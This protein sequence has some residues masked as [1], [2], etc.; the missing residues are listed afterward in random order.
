[1]AAQHLQPNILQRIVD[2]A[3][4][5]ACLVRTAGRLP[6]ASSETKAVTGPDLPNNLLRDEARKHSRAKAKTLV[7]S[8]GEAKFSHIAQTALP[9][10]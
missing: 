10:I 6:L 3:M 8:P 4:C 1:M 9:R 5:K 2:V 7:E